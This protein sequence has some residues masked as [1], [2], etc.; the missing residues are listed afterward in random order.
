MN[1]RR[2]L[3]AFHYHAFSFVPVEHC[4]EGNKSFMNLRTK[5]V[6]NKYSVPINK[7]KGVHG[8][9]IPREYFPAKEL[10]LSDTNGG[11]CN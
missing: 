4:G 3:Y 5:T 6:N 7:S 9:L 2:A 10:L 1:G 11:C 8:Q